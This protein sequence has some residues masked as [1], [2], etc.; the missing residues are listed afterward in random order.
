MF[1]MLN[2]FDFIKNGRIAE[3]QLGQG[4]INVELNMADGLFYEILNSET[5]LNIKGEHELFSVLK[6]LSGIRTEYK[7]SNMLFMKSRPKA[8]A[9]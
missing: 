8:M 7:K 4:R 1:C 9:L 5:G 3:M 2:N 6:E